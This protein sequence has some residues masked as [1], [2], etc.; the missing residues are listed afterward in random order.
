MLDLTIPADI[1]I[2]VGL[3]FDIVGISLLFF[4]APEKFSDP[5]S[6]AFFE[7]EDDSRDVWKKQQRRRE[8][9]AK[10]SVIMIIVGFVLQII[11]VIFF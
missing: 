1:I 9:I 10:I 2:T 5:Q 6:T 4:Y 11:A 7:I 8:C 3:A